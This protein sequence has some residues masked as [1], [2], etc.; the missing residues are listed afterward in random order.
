[1][2]GKETQVR[3]VRMLDVSSLDCTVE[4]CYWEALHVARLTSASWD[5]VLE[6]WDGLMEEGRM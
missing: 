5:Y 6:L 2:A 3:E 1:M 4:D